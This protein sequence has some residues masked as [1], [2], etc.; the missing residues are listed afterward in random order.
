MKG[1][2]SIRRMPTLL[3]EFETEPWLFPFIPQERR[4]DVGV[5][6]RLRVDSI[7]SHFGSPCPPMIH[8]VKAVNQT[9]VVLDL[10]FASHAAERVLFPGPARLRLR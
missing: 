10:K 1:P 8:Q 5:N 3:D 7:S 9:L 4:L 2:L 6:R